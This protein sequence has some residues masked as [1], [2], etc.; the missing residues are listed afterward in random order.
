[1]MRTSFSA[2]S[3]RWASAEM[4]AAIPATVDPDPLA[5]YPGEFLDHGR[6][7]SLLA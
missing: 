7:D 1:M 6:G 4:V 5:D 2:T 3:T